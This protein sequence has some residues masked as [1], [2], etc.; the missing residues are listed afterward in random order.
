MGTD[1]CLQVEALADDRAR[2]SEHVRRLEAAADSHSEDRAASIAV[3]EQLQRELR[4]A[5]CEA[6]ALAD[7][8]RLAEQRGGVA[9][10]AGPPAS[11]GDGGGYVPVQDLVEARAEASDARAEVFAAQQGIR[12]VEGRAL[13]LTRRLR[14]Q[15][16]APENEH[17]VAAEMSLR[18]P[19]DASSVK[20][21]VNLLRQLL[22]SQLC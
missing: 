22:K 15:V 5:R 7:Q 8:C 17:L 13:E 18:Y 12:T 20:V 2:A 19:F 11:Q 21:T 3:I 1:V 16:R 10:G 6:V 9:T 4:E 14:E